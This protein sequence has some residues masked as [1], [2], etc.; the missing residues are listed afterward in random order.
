KSIAAAASQ[1][2]AYA[3]A[4]LATKEAAFAESVFAMNDWLVSLQLRESFDSSRKRWDGGFPR[5]NNG[6]PESSAPDISSSLAAESL[7]DACRVAKAAGDLPRFQR[8][9]RAL[10]LCSYFLTSLQYSPN[11]TAHF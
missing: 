6:K 11:I 8:Y 1:T 9:E 3:E 10:L 7:A 5:L 2:P 4:Y